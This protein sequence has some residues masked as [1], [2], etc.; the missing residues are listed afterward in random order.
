MS[1]AL[2]LTDWQST[3]PMDYYANDSLGP[4]TVNN[5]VNKPPRPVRKTARSKVKIEAAEDSV[6]ATNK[7]KKVA[8]GSS[9]C[10][11]N[12][13]TQCNRSNVDTGT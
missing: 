4:W 9:L 7:A 3:Y 2:R 12:Q 6:N 13:E 5:E 10:C 8:E 11:G 1:V